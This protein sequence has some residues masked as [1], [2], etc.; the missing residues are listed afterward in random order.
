MDARGV[1]LSL[2]AS[3]ANRHDSVLLR[4]TLAGVVYPRPE[5][6]SCKETLC[7]DAAYVGFPALAASRIYNYELNVKTRLQ[8]KDEKRNDPSKQARR[9]VVERTH[10]WFN[11]FR[12]LLVSFEKTEASY[13]GLLSLAAALICW[14]QTVSIY[15]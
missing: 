9:W 11:R 14:R 13:T 4:A 6:G 1:P 2:V 12:K 3:G 8:E 10:S 15:G 5:P 7:A